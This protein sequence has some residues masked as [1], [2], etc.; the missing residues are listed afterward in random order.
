MCYLPKIHLRIKAEFLNNLARDLIVHLLL[1][2]FIIAGLFGAS[3]NWKEPSGS[4]NCNSEST[5]GIKSR[6]GRDAL[7][8]SS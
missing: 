7:N 2:K 5:N 4:P 3:Q 8:K 6:V 1:L